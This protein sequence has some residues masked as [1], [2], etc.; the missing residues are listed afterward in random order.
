M[1]KIKFKYV[2]VTE[3]F[4]WGPAITKLILQFDAKI[5]LKA[6]GSGFFDVYAT[7]SI[8]HGEL[9][10]SGDE[11]VTKPCQVTC[12]YQSDCIGNR[13]EVGDFLAICLAVGPDRIENSPFYYHEKV[14]RNRYV[15]IHFSIALKTN[16]YLTL[17]SGGP[18]ALMPCEEDDQLG[19]VNLI[20]DD[21]EHNQSYA[22]KGVS[23]R[24]ASFKPKGTTGGKTP[25]II[26]LHGAGEGGEETKI[27]VL[28][29][30]VTNLAK[31]L[32]QSHFGDGGAHV[33]VPQAPTMW[34]DLNGDSIYN[35]DLPNSDGKSYYTEALMHLIDDYVDHHYE[36]DRNRIY[37]GGCSNGGYMTIQML[38]HFPDYFAAAFPIAEAY[39]VDWLSEERLERL[40]HIPIWLIH[41]KDDPVVQ[42]ADREGL[43]DH[44]TVALYR[45]LVARGAKD[46]HLSLFE[47]V[48]DTSN[49]YQDQEGNPYTYHG[50]FS[51]IYALNNACGLEIDGKYCRLFEW[52]SSK[53]KAKRL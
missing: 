17:L 10:Y 52:L 13:D 15:A 30:R 36:I 7:R 35:T 24:Y 45:R 50:H 16:K 27:A 40:K 8:L 48:I 51:W 38:I 19:N 53:S 42:V 47:S 46:V 21:F 29:N 43:L 5:A 14:G 6:I 22:Y 4:D 23:L 44:Y 9:G 3:G 33:L 20:C 32:I 26:W 41:S 37:I 34:M 1:E 12:V 28:G 39:H 25:L 11:V 18:C 2:T 31:E 49:T